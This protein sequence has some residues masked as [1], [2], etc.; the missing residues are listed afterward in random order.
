[1]RGMMF[2]KELSLIACNFANMAVL[3]KFVKT[4]LHSLDVKTGKYGWDS[5]SGPG[6]DCS[7]ISS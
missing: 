1:M 6:G 5:A 4:D 7:S 3:Q 2:V